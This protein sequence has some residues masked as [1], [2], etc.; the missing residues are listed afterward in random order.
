MAER[1]QNGAGLEFC[2]MLDSEMAGKMGENM[3]NM[4]RCQD[5]GALEL[6]MQSEE[7]T[8]FVESGKREDRP[9]FTGRRTNNLKQTRWTVQHHV[10]PFFGL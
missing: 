9:H 6:R 8:H 4:E 7:Q 10:E 3:E 5:Y 1:C 2:S